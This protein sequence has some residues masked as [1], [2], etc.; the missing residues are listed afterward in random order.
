[1]RNI[2]NELL[3]KLTYNETYSED[4]LTKSLRL[5]AARWACI[6]DDLRCQHIA[7]TMLKKHLEDAEEY[8]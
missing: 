7:N 8:K 2:L 5:E 4:I 3:N 6:F 1:M